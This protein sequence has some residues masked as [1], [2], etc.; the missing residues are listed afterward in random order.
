MIHKTDTYT[1]SSVNPSGNKPKSRKPERR[2]PGAERQ[3]KLSKQTAPSKSEKTILGS[4][5]FSLTKSGLVGGDS[6]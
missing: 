6:E 3:T 4:K 2:A 5:N 1:L